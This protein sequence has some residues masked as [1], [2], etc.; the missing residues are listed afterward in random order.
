MRRHLQVRVGIC[1][2][3]IATLALTQSSVAAAAG[4]P[5]CPSA[6]GP[7]FLKPLARMPTLP[8]PPSSGKLPFGPPGLRLQS[9]AALRVG[10]GRIGY[11]LRSGGEGDLPDWKLTERLSRVN[12]HGHVTDKLESKTRSLAS[13][14]GSGLAFT[15]RGFGDYYRVDLRIQDGMGKLL[16]SYGA[17]F[18]VVEPTFDPRFRFHRK[19]VAP[20]ETAY[21]RVINFGTE[22]FAEDRTYSVERFDGTTWSEYVAGP[23][24]RGPRVKLGL[25]DGA[26]GRCFAVPIPAGTL[27]GRYRI[28]KEVFWP[29]PPTEPGALFETEEF[30]VGP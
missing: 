8:S 20:G 27:P 4:N 6:A 7:G 30:T 18:R 16:G 25:R 22:T 3:V 24:K 29:L 28:S 9:L 23:S 26:A 5:L 10:R 12:L 11:V 2:A 13:A 14:R 17:Y 21:V 1:A 15:V 19:T